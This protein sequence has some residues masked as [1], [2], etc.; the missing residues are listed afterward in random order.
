[1]AAVVPHTEGQLAQPQPVDTQREQEPVVDEQ[2]QAD[3]SG[4][5]WKNWKR[6][7]INPVGQTDMEEP[8]L[9]RSKRQCRPPDRY[10]PE[11]Y[12][13]LLQVLKSSHHTPKNVLKS[14]IKL[15]TVV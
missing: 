1:M 3:A 5:A 4:L 11:V 7:P 14:M 8:L 2:Q 10:D 12:D 15:M 6:G 13:L 9:L